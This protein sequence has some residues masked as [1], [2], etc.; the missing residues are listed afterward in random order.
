MQD[1][2]VGVEQDVVAGI[3]L[4]KLEKA[5]V[6]RVRRI[7]LFPGLINELLRLGPCFSKVF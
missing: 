3:A 6:E 1:G 7:E 5:R 4:V 2:S